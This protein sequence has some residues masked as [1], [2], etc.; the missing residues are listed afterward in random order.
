MLVFQS[1]AL[2]RGTKI[3]FQ[4]ASLTLHQGEKI[5]VIGHNGCGKSSLFKL[6]VNELETDSG[7]V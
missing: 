5:G 1:A 3:L 6:L 2:R 4:D 7:S